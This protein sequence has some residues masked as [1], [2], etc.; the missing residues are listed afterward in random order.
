[1]A[2]VTWKF[3]GG[4][5][6]F[7]E[8]MQQSGEVNPRISGQPSCLLL[9]KINMDECVYLRVVLGRLWDTVQCQQF[10]GLSDDHS[11]EF[12]VIGLFGHG[13]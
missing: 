8:V 12:K 1:V 6:P 7:A 11:E 3:V 2:R 5:H 10:G 4:G 13:S 9:N